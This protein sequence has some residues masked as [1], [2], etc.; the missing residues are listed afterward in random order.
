MAGTFRYKE[1]QKREQ[2][3]NDSPISQQHNSLQFL[4][5]SQFEENLNFLLNLITA[6]LD[7]SISNI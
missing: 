5:T 7:N 6:Q 3:F 1:N 2:N 4:K